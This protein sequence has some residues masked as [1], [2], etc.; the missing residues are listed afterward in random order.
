MSLGFPRGI[1]LSDF[2]I[3]TLCEDP[4]SA[5]RATYPAYF[6]PN[7]APLRMYFLHLSSYTRMS[8]MENN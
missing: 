8:E 4:L 6:L 1:S 5:I 3:K 2:L 7:V